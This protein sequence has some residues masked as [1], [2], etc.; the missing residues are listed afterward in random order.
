MKIHPR[1]RT[2]DAKFE[3]SWGVIIGPAA[4]AGFG[5]LRRRRSGTAGG[6]GIRGNPEI[7]LKA[8][9]REKKAG[10]TRWLI[11]RQAKGAGVGATRRLSPRLA[12]RSKFG[13]TRRTTVGKPEDAGAGATR[14]LIERRNWR[15]K[16]TGQPGAWL[17]E[18]PKDARIGATRGSIAGPV[19]RC[20]I[21]GNLE[22]CWKTEW[23]DR[24]FRDVWD[25]R[26]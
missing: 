7:H 22:P 24:W 3:S 13:E 1:P 21:R 25:H 26:H 16:E 11:P 6:C 23:D 9:P 18:P 15:S 4:E 5:A 19:G 10:E 17:T 14:S 2:E 20:R 12:G 8:P